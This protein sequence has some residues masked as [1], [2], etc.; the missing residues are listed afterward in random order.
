[1]QQLIILI[2]IHSALYSGGVS[3]WL[4]ALSCH[5]SLPWKNQSSDCGFVPPVNQLYQAALTVSVD[6]LIECRRVRMI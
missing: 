1:M 5:V 4:R 2:I 3:R 6:E